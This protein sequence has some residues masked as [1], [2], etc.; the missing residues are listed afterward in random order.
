MSD[1]AEL[2]KTERKRN[3]S[4]KGDETHRLRPLF[5]PSSGKRAKELYEDAVQHGAKV[6][7]GTAGFEDAKVQPVIV[8]YTAEARLFTEEAFAPSESWCWV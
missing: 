5:D 3:H 4:G 7:A 8:Q 6:I 1:N 2:L